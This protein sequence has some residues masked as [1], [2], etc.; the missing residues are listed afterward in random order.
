MNVKQIN[1]ILTLLITSTLLSAQTPVQIKV[2]GMSCGFCVNGVEK[3]FSK[4]KEVKDLHVDLEKGLVTFNVNKGVKVNK[5]KYMGLIE[6]AGYE[7]RDIKVGDEI[8]IETAPFAKQINYVPEPYEIITRTFK[9]SGNCDMCKKKIETAAKSVKGVKS[10][11]WNA[12][13][14]SITVKYDDNKTKLIDIHNKIASVGY[15]TDKVMA[16]DKTYDKL[17]GCC[18]YERE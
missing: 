18:Q 11:V 7:A 5:D 10:A 8:K 9:V 4:S 14:Q 13:T 1:I 15:D 3:K 17:H 6:K 2:D 16:D 12:E